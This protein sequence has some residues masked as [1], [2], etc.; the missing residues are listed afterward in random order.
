MYTKFWPGNLN[1]KYHSEKLGVGGKIILEWILEEIRW[2]VVHWTH[3]A[4]DRGQWLVPVN[5]IINPWFP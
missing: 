5:M 1:G 4:P 2:K 3:L